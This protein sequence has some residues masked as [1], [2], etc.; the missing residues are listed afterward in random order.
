M[1]IDNFHSLFGRVTRFHYGTSANFNKKLAINPNADK[2]NEGAKATQV[3][4]EQ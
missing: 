4:P 3:L 1:V 2:T